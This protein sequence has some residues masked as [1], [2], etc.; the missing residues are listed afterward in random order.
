MTNQPIK[1]GICV[2]YDWYLL[3]YCLPLIY[4][5]AD[6]ICL[7]LDKNRTG[8]SGKPYSFDEEGFRQ[9]VTTLDTQ[10]KISVLEEDYFVPTATPMQ[11]E[12]RQRNQ[13][14]EYLGDGGWHVQLD[15]DEYFVDFDKFTAYLKSLGSSAGNSN[16]CCSWVTLYKQVDE[17]FLYVDPVTTE[18]L[19]FMQIA[20]HKPHYEV[21]RRNGNFNLYTN[22][23]ILHQSWARNEQEIVEK[24]TNWGHSN[25]FDGAAYVERWKSLNAQNYQQYA[26]FHH[27]NPSVYPRLGLVTG[28]T[29][30][31]VI[32]HFKKM[33]FPTFTSTELYFKNS[34]FFSRVRKLLKR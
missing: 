1:V 12:V 18:N 31:E 24:I 3:K 27:L 21:S 8:W 9:L 26:N 23:R 2:A 34:L 11:N 6:T 7:S 20:S 14:A 16:V 32:G 10:K 4:P 28:K 25:D 13:I 17:G 30:T 15:C 19:E 22:F 33:D 29:I 5:F